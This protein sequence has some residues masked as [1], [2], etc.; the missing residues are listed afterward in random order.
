MSGG[1]CLPLEANGHGLSSKRCVENRDYMVVF[2]G[3]SLCRPE[4]P[5]SQLD[6]SL[7]FSLGTCV[8]LELLYRGTFLLYAGSSNP[9]FLYLFGCFDRHRQRPRV[10]PKASAAFCYFRVGRWRETS[11]AVVGLRTRTVISRRVC[12]WG[13]AFKARVWIYLSVRVAFRCCTRLWPQHTRG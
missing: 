10:I 13:R 1:V 9:D 6:L 2:R 7:A 8:Q 11:G 12:G 5:V 3:N 4:L